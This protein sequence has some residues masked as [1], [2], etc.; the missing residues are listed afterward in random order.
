[1]PEARREVARAVQTFIVAAEEAK[2]LGG[3][4]VP[5]DWTPGLERYVGMVRRVPVGPVLG[6]TP[7]NFPLNLVAH[8]VAPALA[9]GN[10]ILIKPAPQTPLTALLLGE[11]VREVGL[12]SG[13]L[14]VVPCDNQVAQRLVEDPRFKL[15]SFTGSAPVGWM[16]KAK[17]GKNSAAMP[18]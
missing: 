12:P 9:A 13:A 14:N 6:I 1:M 15:L 7:F 16:L 5:M 10:A 18:G 17:A 2:R 4:V 8:K 3:E 11:I